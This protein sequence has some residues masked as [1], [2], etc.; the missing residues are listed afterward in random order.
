MTAELDEQQK[1]DGWML[2]KCV[3]PC[4]KHNERPK[5]GHQKPFYVRLQR[6][7]NCRHTNSHEALMTMYDETTTRSNSV[8]RH[9]KSQTCTGEPAGSAAAS[10]LEDVAST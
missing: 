6:A 9:R 4:D 2:P 10:E 7:F 3:I 1:M 8:L 5:A